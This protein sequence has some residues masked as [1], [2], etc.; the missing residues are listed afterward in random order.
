MIVSR[1]D[2]VAGDYVQGI[3]DDLTDPGTAGLLR[4][5][6]PVDGRDVLDIACGHGRV[7][8]ELARRG[9]RVTG[10]DLSHALID[11]ARETECAEV[12]GITYVATDAAGWMDAHPASFDVVTCNFGLS[13]VDDLPGV[14]DGVAAVLR[15]GGVFIA[16]IL[17][18]C[19]PGWEDRAPSSWDPGFG[20]F[21]E[22][23]WKPDAPRSW[24]RRQVGANHRTLSTYARYLL[25]AGLSIDDLLEPEPPPEWVANGMTPLP[26][27]LVLRCVKPSRS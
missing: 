21:H 8:R 27:F 13:D 25:T 5:L 23:W 6:P 11:R 12:L 1:Y 7:A 14:T 18:P 24:I 9:G 20:Y 26:T 2:A 15:P 4:S 3:G 19:F 17:H 22:T 16:S 10:V